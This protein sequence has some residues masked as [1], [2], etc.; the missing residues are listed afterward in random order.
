MQMNEFEYVEQCK[1]NP[2]VKFD[3][4]TPRTIKNLL[5]ARTA[6]GPKITFDQVAQAIDELIGLNYSLINRILE[7]TAYYCSKG[8]L[9]IYCHDQPRSLGSEERKQRH[10]C[11]DKSNGLIILSTHKPLAQVLIHELAHVANH[12]TAIFNDR[13]GV[14]QH[15]HFCKHTFPTLFSQALTSSKPTVEEEN[16]LNSIE[17]DIKGLRELM[18]PYL[19]SC[20]SAGWHRMMDRYERGSQIFA[21]RRR[22][23]V[24]QQQLRRDFY[25]DFEPYMKSEYAEE[26]LPFFLQR[27][28]QFSCHEKLDSLQSWV[29]NYVP[30]G[31]NHLVEIYNAKLLGMM[32]SSLPELVVK[33]FIKGDFRIALE[34]LAD[35]LYSAL[36]KEG[37]PALNDSIIYAVL[38]SSEPLIKNS[39]MLNK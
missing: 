32:W 8:L 26:F 10:G 11:Y 19:Q 17:D 30:D 36:H 29:K 4:N 21:V 15:K 5:L 27:F 28:V 2:L 18:T 22:K 1:K 9:F 7:V 14:D 20:S 33:N 35:K 25:S 3:N 6:I 39:I 37:V 38:S 34:R 23:V 31:Q 12:F 16:E 24:A 13:E